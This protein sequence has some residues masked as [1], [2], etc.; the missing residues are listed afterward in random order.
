MGPPAGHCFLWVNLKAKM[1]ACF[2]QTFKQVEQNHTHMLN[3]WNRI[4]PYATCSGSHSLFV[5]VQG[6]EHRLPNTRLAARHWGILLHTVLPLCAEGTWMQNL[7][8][9]GRFF[10]SVTLYYLFSK[11]KDRVTTAGL[12]YGKSKLKKK[13][14]WTELREVGK[15]RYGEGR[16]KVRG[17]IRF[18]AQ[19]QN[20]QL[21]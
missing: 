6:T 12:E 18:K 11:Y 13:E 17:K 4:C 20:C 2:F 21:M 8:P 14:K 10:F 1:K 7:P 5:V 16:R 19:K 15:G 3:R 9:S